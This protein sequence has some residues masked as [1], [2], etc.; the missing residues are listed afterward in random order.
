MQR[1]KTRINMAHI[2]ILAAVTLTVFLVT[3]LMYTTLPHQISI[4]LASAGT[5][6]IWFLA[7]TW[8]P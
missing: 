2:R 5:A 3:T 1:Q 8:R 4:I 6:S 7:A